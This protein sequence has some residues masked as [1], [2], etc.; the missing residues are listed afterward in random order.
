[1]D[2]IQLREKE[3]SV[4]DM[5][6]LAR[7]AVEAV[8]AGTNTR[9]LI[10][11][12]SD[13]AIACHADGVHLRGDDISAKEAGE[14]WRKAGV[15]E[16]VIS[17]SC[18]T[19]AEVKRAAAQAAT[20]AVFAPVFEKLGIGV[21]PAGLEKLA[22]ACR[23]KIPVLALG[24]ITLENAPACVRAGAAGVAGIRLFQENDLETT[25]QRLR[26]LT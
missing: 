4:R 11:S 6:I 20:F 23:E 14:I 21:G 24:G 15:P 1:V 22:D 8:R 12:R 9:L 17:V 25:V 2:F 18:H 5:E 3:L 26:G 19:R 7:R 13:V 10:N 16:S